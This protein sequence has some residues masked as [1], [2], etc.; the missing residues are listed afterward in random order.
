[1][2]VTFKAVM[3]ILTKLEGDKIV[4]LKTSTGTE[5]IGK[6]DEVKGIMNTYYK[7]QINIRYDLI[8]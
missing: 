8:C 5:L 3:L 7:N 4:T 2:I 6:V 1:M